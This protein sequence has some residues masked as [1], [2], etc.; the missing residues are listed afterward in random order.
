MGRQFRRDLRHNGGFH[1]PDIG[2]NSVRRQERRDSSRGR[3]TGADG[4]ADNNKIRAGESATDIAAGLIREIKRPNPRHHPGRGVV[5][6][7]FSGSP[8]G[9]GGPRDGGADQARADEGDAR[10]NGISHAR[11][12]SPRFS[13]IA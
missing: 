8:E 13:P 4:R 12:F 10:E 2:N 7:D 5:N 3:A 9:A 6:R 11:F 1:R